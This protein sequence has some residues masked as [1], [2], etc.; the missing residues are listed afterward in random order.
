VLGVFGRNT[1]GD[2]TEWTEFGG[3]YTSAEPAVCGDPVFVSV[4]TVLAPPFVAGAH[5]AVGATVIV[6]VLS[7]A[8]AIGMTTAAIAT[9]RTAATPHVALR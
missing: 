2:V 8:F 6:Y 4:T 5:S 3:K 7:A 9:T 1:H